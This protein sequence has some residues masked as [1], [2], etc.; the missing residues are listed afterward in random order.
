MVF[1]ICGVVCYG[2]ME[3]TAMPIFENICYLNKIIDGVHYLWIE[4]AVA[5]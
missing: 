4:S 3:S 1:I 5:M 2:R